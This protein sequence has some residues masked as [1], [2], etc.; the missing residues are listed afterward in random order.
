[1]DIMV[2][3]AKMSDV[4][5]I[6]TILRELQWFDTIDSRILRG[7]KK[8]SKRTITIMPGR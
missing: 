4:V 6:T 5:G 8:S 3:E 7:I 1:M 2:R